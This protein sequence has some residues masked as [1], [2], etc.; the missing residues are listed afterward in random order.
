MN[1]LSCRWEVSYYKPLNWSVC[2]ILGTCLTGC[3]IRIYLLGYGLIFMSTY[4]QSDKVEL[5]IMH[6]NKLIIKLRDGNRVSSIYY[7]TCCFYIFPTKDTLREKS[8]H[9]HVA[10]L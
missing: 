10:K 5:Y 4:R 1:G 8:A 7:L 2:S 3:C 6:T 9:P